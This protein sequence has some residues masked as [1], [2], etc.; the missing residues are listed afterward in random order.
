MNGHVL[1]YPNHVLM[2]Y[3]EAQVRDWEG[4]CEVVNEHWNDVIELASEALSKALID[5]NVANVVWWAVNRLRER[6]D[7]EGMNF[8]KVR[9]VGSVV[10]W[11]EEEGV[12]A[13]V[14]VDGRNRRVLVVVEGKLSDYK[15]KVVLDVGKWLTPDLTFVLMLKKR[16]RG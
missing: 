15:W 14:L 4:I 11:I 6:M 1:E 9:G 12:V 16:D 7:R 3:D 2:L 5:L 10:G 8:W 13:K